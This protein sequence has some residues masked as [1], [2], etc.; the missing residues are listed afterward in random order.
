M[1]TA[2][3][4]HGGLFSALPFTIVLATAMLLQ[5]LVNFTNDFFD[6]RSGVDNENRLGPTR[7]ISS[8]IMSEK[9]MLTGIIIISIATAGLLTYLFIRGGA[10]VLA[11]GLAA[12]MTA[13]LYSGTRFSIA[14]HAL[15]EL[16]AFTFFGPVG[17]V[18][19]CYLIGLSVPREVFV[20]S[21]PLGLL[22]AAVLTVNNYRDIFTDAEAGKRTLPVHL[23]IKG[24]RILF[25]SYYVIAYL[26]LP[27]LIL[28]Y[29]MTPWI[30]L[31]LISLP[32]SILSI[33]PIL[34]T[35]PGKHL[36][37][38]LAIT[39]LNCLLFSLAFSIGLLIG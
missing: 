26:L 3:S 27:F 1:G 24:T 21:L 36:N 30:C 20:S 6:A 23:G 31:A 37:R 9:E 15:G 29:D 10:V 38:T 32:V 28:F 12:L 17:V 33:V 13:F 18:G 35:M 14:S 22:V 7:V 16:F 39:S 19:S 5:I 25:V 11:I 34:K 2:F 8:R 4:I